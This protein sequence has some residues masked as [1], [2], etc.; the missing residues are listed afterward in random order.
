MT[1]V[2]GVKY[3]GVEQCFQLMKSFGTADHAR[4]AERMQTADPKEAYAIGRT[5]AMR[6]D[7]D[8]VKVL[9]ASRDP[10]TGVGRI[11]A[12]GVSREVRTESS[13]A[14]TANLHRPVPSRSSKTT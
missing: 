13:S 6:A 14:R 4:A 3:G 11:D 5:F 8:D 2:D 12:K 7:W 1:V 10:F 9:P